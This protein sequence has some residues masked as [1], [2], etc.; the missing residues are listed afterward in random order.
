MT[1]TSALVGTTLTAPVIGASKNQPAQ[2]TSTSEGQGTITVDIQVPSPG[3]Y[4]FQVGLWQDSSGPKWSNLTLR[5]MILLN[6]IA[7]L[8][9]GQACTAADMQAQLPAPTNPPGVFICP[10]GP[11]Q[12]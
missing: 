3:T 6:H 1:F 7:H 9:S 8:W 5:Q 10:G 11:P 4:T 2:I 12:Q